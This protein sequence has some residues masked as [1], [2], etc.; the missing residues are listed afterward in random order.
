MINLILVSKQP[1]VNLRLREQLLTDEELEVLDEISNAD[2]ALEK[3]DLQNPNILLLYS[4]DAD[5]DAISLAERVIQ[6]KPR[7]FVILLMERMTMER[8]QLATAAGCHNVFP[9]PENA[10]ELCALVHRVYNA[11]NDRINALDS[12]ERA[13]WASKILSVYSAKGG[14]GKTTIATNL[15]L[16]LARQKKKVCLID[17]DLL[18]GDVHVFMDVEPKETISDLMQENFR[19]SI[20]SVRSFMTVHPSGIHILCSPKAPEYADTVSGERVQSLLSL[21]RAYY[22]YIIIDTPV[23]FSDPTLAAL[24]ASTSILFVTGLEVSILKNSKMAMTVLDSLGQKKKVRTIIN[25]AVEINSI[26]AGDVQRILDAPI[27]S[28]I[29]SEYLV[30][31]AA[32]NQ[33]L[34][35]VKSAPKAKISLAI[36]DIADKL[37]RGDD[38]YDMVQLTAKEKRA[39]N[40]R[41]K[42][43]DK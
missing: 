34:P 2:E 19:N 9:V 11:E 23:N 26:N 24:E 7:T 37:V 28:R 25:R 32:I 18:F 42:S 33:G 22:D 36:A 30:A 39:L 27:L 3:V 1:S 8:L 4:G 17:L 40:K 5:S 13:T 29:P 14:I 41:Y 31:V 15:A 38:T 20:D 12:N 10:K 21:L 16:E 43:K 6:R 35:F